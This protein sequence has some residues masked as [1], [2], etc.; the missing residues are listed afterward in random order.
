VIVGHA[1]KLDGI[2]KKD[3]AIPGRSHH[4]KKAIASGSAGACATRDQ[5]AF[6]D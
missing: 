5:D 1:L 4:A 6:A 2:L 3:H